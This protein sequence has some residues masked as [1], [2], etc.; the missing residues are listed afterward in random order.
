MVIIKQSVGID[1]SK[2]KLDVIF[3]EQSDNGVTIKGS[4]KFD[5]TLVGFL[6]LLGWCDKRIKTKN[7]IF[8]LEATGIYHEDLLYFLHDNGKRVCVELPQ[9]IKYFAKSKGVKTKNDK[10]DS[11]VIADYGIERTLKIWQPPSPQF[12]TLRDFSREHRAL[13][14]AKTIAM[15]RLHADQHAHEKD[16]GV[17]ER[18][19]AQIEFYNQQIEKVKTD[20]KVVIKADEKLSKKLQK[21]ETI[22]GVGLITIV[23]VIAETGGFYLFNNINQLI[24][25]AGLDVIENQ[26]GNH[27]GKTRISKKGN[28]NLRTAVYMP[29]LSAI[30]FN[31]KMKAL[32]DRIMETHKYKKQGIVAVMRKLLILIYTLWKKDEEYD[33]DYEWGTKKEQATVMA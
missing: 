4:K 18:T 24:S 9:R 11:G 3:K 14:D 22:K 31:D 28:S 8:V 2:D 23:T 16:T 19:Q 32:N 6:L 10:I 17:I 21:I 12:K 15:N 29:A 27:K 5:N 7:I 13:N 26:S 33:P 1:V 30:R 20:I 25:Y